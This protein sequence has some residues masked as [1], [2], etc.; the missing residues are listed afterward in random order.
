MAKAK[1]KKTAPQKPKA[2]SG[3]EAKKAAPGKPE[4]KKPP[5]KKTSASPAPNPDD[6]ETEM[7]TPTP[8]EKTESPL[9]ESTYA[10]TAEISAGDVASNRQDAAAP[11]MPSGDPFRS[12]GRGRSLGPAELSLLR[13]HTI[14]LNAG[15]FSS[16][17]QLCTSPPD[18]EAIFGEF[19]PQWIEN[20]DDD[21]TPRVVL[22]AHGGLISEDA[23][24]EIALR[25]IAFW[26]SNGIYP[27]FFIWET[28]FIESI[29][30]LWSGETRR[31]R[32]LAATRGW[33]DDARDRVWEELSRTLGVRHIWSGM[34]RSAERT[35]QSEGDGGFVI[36][37]LR[38]L[39]SQNKNTKLHLVGHSAGAIF[40]AHGLPPLADAGVE[41]DSL[42]L[43]APAATNELFRQKIMP[44]VGKGKP[45]RHCSIFTML[46]EYELDDTV[47]P[48][49]K[50]LLYL[51]HHALETR[52]ETPISGLEV[53]L[54]SDR[55]LAKFF[56]LGS[57]P[58]TPHGEVI[59]SVT[60]QSTGAAA[61]QATTHGMFDDD[62]ATM[63]SIVRRIKRL[64]DGQPVA[65]FVSRGLHVP[66][67]EPWGASARFNPEQG[68]RQMGFEMY[69][70]SATRGSTHRDL[71]V[72]GGSNRGSNKRALCIGID[73]Y[74]EPADRL[75]GC[76]NDARE[77]QDVF[78]SRGFDVETMTDREATRRGLLDAMR[79]I[80]SGS[81][82]GDVIA[83]QLSCHGTQVKDYNGDEEDRR[84][85]AVVP[86]DHRTEG[87][88]VDDDIADIADDIPEG[89]SV[90]FFMD[91]CHSGSATRLLVGALDR[92][93]SDAKVRFL[94]ADAQMEEIHRKTA[95]RGRSKKRDAY[96]DRPEMLFAACAPHQT[97]KERG[98]QGDFTRYAL[99]V[100]RDA[101]DNLTNAQFID[102]VLKI[103]RFENQDPALWADKSLH[104][105]KILSVHDR[106]VSQGKQDCSGES[107]AEAIRDIEQALQRLRKTTMP[108]ENHRPTIK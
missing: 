63:Q 19:I 62:P 106:G 50:S 31:S 10:T 54:R 41:I 105:R 6:S 93:S 1:E 15:Q 40:W 9:D 45:V 86:Y 88:L 13:R 60:R 82:A 21:E 20:R 101:G 97:A 79:S 57:H 102:E 14:N 74:P 104:N 70:G 71:S 53:S 87:Y 85:E 35:F 64:E 73:R 43:L 83:I 77:W 69:Q 91:L 24:A 2:P 16:D 90:S 30:Q 100:L 67:P 11:A 39:L 38:E 103:G 29:M 26:T 58:A 107:S 34:K 108:V 80:I 46:K 44:R 92:H 98:G 17:G 66:S 42:H 4:P 36:D 94:A 68:Y 75:G 78:R 89:V 28:G 32:E 8:Q 99:K 56:G 18:V 72:S 47:G 65:R 7:A 23:G 61:S 49:R 48:Y 55:K 12:A 96:K 84:D 33:Y 81:D 95:S 59:W 51:I 27:V 5:A 22:Y 25:N 3:G 52:R 76:V 37:Q